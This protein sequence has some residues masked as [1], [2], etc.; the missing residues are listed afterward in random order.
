MLYAY[1]YHKNHNQTN[2]KSSIISLKNPKANFLNLSIN[3]SN[4]IDENILFE[5]EDYLTEFAIGLMDD[6]IEYKHNEKHKYC[7]IC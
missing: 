7:M 3:G 2:L 6:H 5:F 4:T 1:L